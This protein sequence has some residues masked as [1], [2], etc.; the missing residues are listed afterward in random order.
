[1]LPVVNF[2]SIDLE[3]GS[4]SSQET[5]ALEEFDARTGVF[6]VERRR[7]SGEPAPDYGYA[8]ESHERTTTRNF[9]V[10]ESAARARSGSPGSRSIFLS[11]S[12]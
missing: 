11:S 6:E 10:F 2:D 3:R 1:M 7:K 4:A 5:A 12:S 9:S 8:L